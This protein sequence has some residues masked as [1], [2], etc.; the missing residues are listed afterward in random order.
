VLIRSGGIDDVVIR[1]KNVGQCDVSE[2]S[3]FSGGIR[4]VDA[5]KMAAS[6]GY[7]GIEFLVGI[8]GTIGGAIA[9]N[10]GAD[11]DEVANVLLWV[12]LMNAKGEIERVKRRHINM[13]Y[14]NGGITDGLIVV[15]ACFRLNPSTQDKVAMRHAK[16][17]CERA[18]KMNFGKN[19]GTAGS[20]FRN[21]LNE[22]SGGRK[23]WELIDAAGCRGLSR[24]G[25]TVSEK[26]ANFLLN[27]GN[28]TPEDIENLGEEVRKR[29]LDATG[30]QLEWEIKILGK[31]P[32]PL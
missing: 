18:A 29:V 6:A 23:A 5:C 13:T 30:V 21:P 15:R 4:N 14:R 2:Q 9:M 32:T 8:P 28:A 31:K 1:L 12:D 24:G 22:I 3:V 11:G 10:A 16:L 19:V 20:A 7:S 26:H 17:L 25:V 27:M